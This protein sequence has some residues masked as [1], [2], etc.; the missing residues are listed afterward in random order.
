MM[1]F[2]FSTPVERRGTASLKWDKYCGTDII[3][4]WLADMDF[5]SPPAVVE[6]LQQ[7]V[8]HGV[9]G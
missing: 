3:P 9:F 6:A 4:M 8:A 1:P 5:H 2:D 7:R